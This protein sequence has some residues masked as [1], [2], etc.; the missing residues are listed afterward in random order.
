M[1]RTFRDAESEVRL[2]KSRIEALE[3]EKSVSKPVQP[4]VREIIRETKTVESL[5][6]QLVADSNTVLHALN[7][8]FTTIRLKNL[9]A[10]NVNIQSETDVPQ[11]HISNDKT[12]QG[13]YILN[14]GNDT[15][16]ASGATYNGTSWVA[17]NTNAII[18]SLTVVEGFRYFYNAALVVG[19]TF[20]PSLKAQISIS[21]IVTLINTINGTNLVLS[22]LDANEY[23]GTNGSKQLI[24][25]DDTSFRTAVDVYSKSETDSA[26]AAAIAAI[27]LSTYVTKAVYSVTIANNGSHNHG[28][29]V[30]A[31]G[32]HGHGAS[33][34]LT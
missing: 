34:D 16:I 24:S 31:D 1:I 23:V 11:L 4:P 27:D 18:I 21:G 28:G 15:Y 2:L 26:I 17:V 5:D 19:S 14:L 3:K 6:A 7:H 29:A 30:A 22:G 12:E 20:I 33:V 9:L 10:E 32:I 8:I 13:T 25:Y